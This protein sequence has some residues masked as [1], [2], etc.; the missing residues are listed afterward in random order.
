[1]GAEVLA[2]LSAGRHVWQRCSLGD[3]LFSVFLFRCFCFGVLFRCFCFRCFVSVFLFSLF[4]FGV[5]VSVLCFR[6]FVFGVFD[7]RGFILGVF[8]SRYFLEYKITTPESSLEGLFYFWC[9]KKNKHLK[10]FY[11][12]DLIPYT[13]S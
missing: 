3:V 1:M 8:F 11:F 13:Y 2:I 6:C 12:H 5:F 9:L 7:L 10:I 4:C